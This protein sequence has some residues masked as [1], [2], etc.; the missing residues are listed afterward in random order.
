MLLGLTEKERRIARGITDFAE[1][2]DREYEIIE[3]DSTEEPDIVLIDID[4]PEA[5][6]A[7]QQKKFS[8]RNIMVIISEHDLPEK[9][10][11]L[12]IKRPLVGLQIWETIHKITIKNYK[13]APELKISA[14]AIIDGLTEKVLSGS[15]EEKKEKSS[16][17][18]SVCVVD[19]SLALRAV[20]SM[21]LDLHGIHAT[22]AVDGADAF[23]VLKSNQFDAIFLDTNLPDIDGYKICKYIKSNKA[24]QNTPVIML[25]GSTKVRSKFRGKMAGCDAYL[26]KPVEQEE[27][28]ATIERFLPEYSNNV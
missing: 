15:K 22:H 13:Y 17:K 14:S 11:T 24:I 21:Q 1:N 16:A 20:L 27:L 25:T 19:D 10:K 23:K 26:T 28:Q 6:S 7:F 5:V 4:S 18:Y 8:K 12:F 3:S 2:E 9:T